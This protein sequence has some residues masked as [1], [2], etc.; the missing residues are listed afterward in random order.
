MKHSPWNNYGAKCHIGPKRVFPIG[1]AWIWAGSLMEL[2]GDTSWSLMVRIAD[3]W[4][5]FPAITEVKLNP[6]AKALLHKHL[7]DRPSPPTVDMIW[8]DFA[9]PTLEIDWWK[10]LLKG[11]ESLPGKEPNVVVHCV[12]GHGR[13]GTVL[14]ILAGLSGAWKGKAKDPVTFIRNAYCQEAVEGSNQVDYIRKITK[15]PLKGVVGAWAL[16]QTKWNTTTNGVSVSHTKPAVVDD[17]NDKVYRIGDSLY[18]KL[19]DGSML[20]IGEDDG[21]YIGPNHQNNVEITTSVK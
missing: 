7:P 21:S 4:G 6:E 17:S 5:D 20:F 10:S 15:H 13:T 8:Q 3:R 2:E 11:I 14:S 16:K 19:Q 9:S 1:K 18:Q 12:G